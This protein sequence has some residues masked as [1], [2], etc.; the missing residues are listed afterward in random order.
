MSIAYDIQGTGCT[1]ANSWG[2]VLSDVW[3]VIRGLLW[4]RRI[5]FLSM[6]LALDQVVQFMRELHK[7]MVVFFHCDLL[8]R[9]MHSFAFFGRKS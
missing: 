2:R 8:T 3:L 1:A 4:L 7:F 5:C 9:P 6:F